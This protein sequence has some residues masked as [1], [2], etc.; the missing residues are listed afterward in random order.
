MVMFYSNFLK[1]GP[2]LRPAN[3]ILPAFFFLETA[4]FRDSTEPGDQKGPDSGT[5]HSCHT[6]SLLSLRQGAAGLDSGQPGNGAGVRWGPD[7]S[8]LQL[9]G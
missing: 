7:A 4:L 8:Q 9:S 5:S 2:S 1:L 3:P 6:S